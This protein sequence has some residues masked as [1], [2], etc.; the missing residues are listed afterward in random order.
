[1]KRLL[2]I[3]I[4]LCT[5]ISSVLIGKPLPFG[6]PTIPDKI[7]DQP[8]KTDELGC[9]DVEGTMRIYID[10]LKISI[11]NAAKILTKQAKELNSIR[12]KDNPHRKERADNLFFDR[13]NRFL[14]IEKIKRE[15]Q[16]Q[17]ENSE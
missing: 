16:E 15:K 2:F 4:F 11:E 14:F 10:E 13:M 9:V 17:Q 7:S 1:M 6:D 3:T 8:L 12:F 5:T